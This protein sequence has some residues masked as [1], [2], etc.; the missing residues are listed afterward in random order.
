MVLAR[1]TI[2]EPK[3]STIALDE[4]HTGTWFDFFMGEITD[5]PLW[6]FNHLIERLGVVPHVLY[7][8]ASECRRSLLVRLRFE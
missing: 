7:P 2:L 6:H 8:S 4:H 1:L 5:S 3:D